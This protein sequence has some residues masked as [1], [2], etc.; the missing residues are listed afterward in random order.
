MVLSGIYLI[1]V[2][3]MDE[4][5]MSLYIGDYAEDRLYAIASQKM[6]DV[7]HAHKGERILFIERQRH[8]D[9]SKRIYIYC[10][11]VNGC[12]SQDGV[13]YVVEFKRHGDVEYVPLVTY[14]THMR[15]IKI[16]AMFE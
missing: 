13:K 6:M 15:I 12:L 9:N 2:S 1:D 4:A 5:D 16:D 7:L 14:E 10:N 8:T 3:V 11:L